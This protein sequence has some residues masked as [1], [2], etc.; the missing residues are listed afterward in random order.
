VL[1][2]W[3]RVVVVVVVVANRKKIW[4]MRLLETMVKT[5]RDRGGMEEMVAEVSY[6]LLLI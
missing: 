6:L 3:D 1:V 2:G 5:V 4:G